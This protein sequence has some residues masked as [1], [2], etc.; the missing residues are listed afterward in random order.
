MAVKYVPR[1]E[2]T[3]ILN[4]YENKDADLLRGKRA[5][6]QRLWFRYIDS[7]TSLLPKSEISSL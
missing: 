5:T 7:T 6:D 2:K 4:I 1:H 3:G